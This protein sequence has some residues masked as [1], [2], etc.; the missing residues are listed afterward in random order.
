MTAH[1]SL[2]SYTTGFILSI[3]LTLI[4]Y[5]IVVEKLLAGALLIVTIILFAV[6]QLLVQAIFF[7][8]LGQESKPRWN[9]M[10]FLFMLII[11]GILVLG[12]LWIMY[13]LDYNMMSPM[14]TNKF[15]EE[16]ERISR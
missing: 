4:P 16:E 10:I 11:V 13:N 9:L 15:I 7:L 14:E 6:V 1:S 3:I 8:H 2:K 12:T 5:L